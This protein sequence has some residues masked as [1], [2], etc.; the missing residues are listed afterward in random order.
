MS[1]NHFPGR[2]LLFWSAGGAAEVSAARDFVTRWNC[3]VRKVSVEEAGVDVAYACK[4]VIND[5]V[6]PLVR[7]FVHALASF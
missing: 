4:A 6:A 5:P 2:S 3:I 7:V 1:R